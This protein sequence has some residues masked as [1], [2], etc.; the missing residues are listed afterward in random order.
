MLVI[1][2]FGVIRACISQDIHDK[3]DMW[4]GC[5]FIGSVTIMC[6]TNEALF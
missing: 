1:L 2:W 3:D 4:L 6:R 5:S